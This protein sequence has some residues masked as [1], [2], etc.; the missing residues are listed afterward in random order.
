MPCS[1]SDPTG[2]AVVI[3]VPEDA[4]RLDPYQD[5]VQEESVAFKEGGDRRLLDMRVPY[6]NR[7]V[8]SELG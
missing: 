1:T 2:A 5:L 3:A 6:V 4:G 7:A 8:L